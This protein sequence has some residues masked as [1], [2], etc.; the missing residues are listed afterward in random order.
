MPL[1]IKSLQHLFYNLSLEN[2]HCYSDISSV[3]FII[4]IETITGNCLMVLG[5]ATFLPQ[6]V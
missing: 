4:V 6:V 1:Y 3:P 2:H 5:C